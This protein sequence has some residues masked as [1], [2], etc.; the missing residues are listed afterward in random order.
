MWEWVPVLDKTNQFD[1]QVVAAVGTVLLP[2]I[3]Q[4][5]I[6]FTHPFGYDW[7]CYVSVDAAF[8][9]LLAK[10]NREGIDYCPGRTREEEYGL[11]GGVL[12][13][14]TD[15]PLVPPPFQPL[16]GDRIVVWG[17]WIVDAGHDDFHTEIHP[18]LLMTSAHDS[19]GLTRSTLI[20][21]PYLT[22]QD[23]GDGALAQH[24]VN[25]IFKMLP[26]PA[27]PA[28][29]CFASVQSGHVVA[30]P[31]IF[32]MPFE[33][34]KYLSYVV[35]PLHDRPNANEQLIAQ[36]DFYVRP[37]V[38]VELI[39]ESAK[40]GAIRVLIHMDGD[41]YLPHRRPGTE[42]VNYTIDQL[43]ER[44]PGLGQAIKLGLAANQIL[45][46]TS[47][48]F[49]CQAWF[50][51]AINGGV[52]TVSY[53]APTYPDAN[54]TTVAAGRLRSVPHYAIDVSQAFPVV[55]WLNVAWE[56]E[57]EKALQAQC[58]VLQAQL[59]GLSH[60]I[61]ALKKSLADGGDNRL[62]KIILSLERAAAAFKADARKQGCNLR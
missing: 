36:F 27:A 39:D 38:T 46:I 41:K 40:T 52:L 4:N 34:Q 5:D 13:I 49:L 48:D 14:E 29:L 43:D 15:N 57:Y 28:P 21:R 18:P 24:L 51:S 32:T 30:E 60:R 26:I 42:E 61:D 1:A 6:P 59:N 2:E 35:R 33:G 16:E 47:L 44:H 37:G 22:D 62:L 45:N 54:L 50:D 11:N 7:E 53:D 10:G 3:S 31:S 23:F 56:S 8:Q 58:A 20:S 9:S 25:E 12:G 19:F 17:R 55:G